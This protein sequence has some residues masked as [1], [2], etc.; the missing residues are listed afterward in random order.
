MSTLSYRAQEQMPPR[1]LLSLQPGRHMMVRS[2]TVASPLS[3]PWP[4]TLRDG[5]FGQ[6]I[7]SFSFLR[8]VSPA[9]KLGLMRTMTP[10]IQPSFLHYQSRVERYKVLLQLSTQLEHGVT[11]LTS[12]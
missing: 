4:T 8:T 12:C 11:A 6:R 7:S 5:H 2:T 9:H 3:S 10:T 1:P